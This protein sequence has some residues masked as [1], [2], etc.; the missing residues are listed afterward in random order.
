[1]TAAIA[2]SSA[3]WRTTSSNVNSPWLALAAAAASMSPW[4]FGMPSVVEMI[5]RATAEFENHEHL[6]VEHVDLTTRIVGR[7]TV[8]RRRSRSSIVWCLKS[9]DVKTFYRRFEIQRNT[10]VSGVSGP[11][12]SRK[13]RYRNRGIPHVAAAQ[14]DGGR[15]VPYR[16][17]GWQFHCGSPQHETGRQVCRS[18]SLRQRLPHGGLL[19]EEPGVCRRR[20]WT[21]SAPLSGPS[22]RSHIAKSRNIQIFLVNTGRS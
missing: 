18:R 7:H 19:R 22:M 5:R 2:G 3:N 10:G 4:K 12:S 9:T 20:H 6:A 1:M 16:S 15:N 17:E 11:A 14:S 8:T 21:H 13:C